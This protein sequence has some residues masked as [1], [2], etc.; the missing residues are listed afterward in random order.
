MAS[1]KQNSKTKKSGFF[2]FFVRPIEISIH[3]EISSR[4]Y[5]SYI[6]RSYALD[7]ALSNALSTMVI[8]PIEKI[9][10]TFKVAHKNEKSKN[11]NLN[12]K[13]LHQSLKKNSHKFLCFFSNYFN[14]RKPYRAKKKISLTN[15]YMVYLI[16][17]KFF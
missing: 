14:N 2:D 1:W 6:T 3:R 11:S 15:S 9:E 12:R 17:I 8:R 13:K 4:L 5:Y 7:H 10:Q 16:L